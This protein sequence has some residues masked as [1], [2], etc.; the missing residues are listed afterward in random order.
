MAR[1]AYGS[2][3]SHRPEQAVIDLND[4]LHRLTRYP[5]AS[6][7]PTVCRDDDATLEPKA[8]G[9]CTVGKL[10]GAVGIRGVIGLGPEPACRLL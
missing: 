7:R 4:L 3:T 5:I 2:S 8:Q 1:K 9:R 6:R 10:D